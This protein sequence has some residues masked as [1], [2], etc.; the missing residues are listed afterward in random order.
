MIMLACRVGSA[1]VRT[2]ATGAIAPVNF[3]KGIFA[4]VDL[5]LLI[6]A[7][8]KLHLSIWKPLAFE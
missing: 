6:I 1:V 3:E 7:H 8:A 2:V 5:R 4:P